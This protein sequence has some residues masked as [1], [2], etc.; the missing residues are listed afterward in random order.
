[1][2]DKDKRAIYDQQC[3]VIRKKNEKQ[4]QSKFAEHERRKHRKS[5]RKSRPKITRLPSHNGQKP[6][7][8]PK[9][10]DTRNNASKESV[11]LSG[12]D[13]DETHSSYS[14]AQLMTHLEHRIDM[15]E[16]EIDEL[17]RLD[18]EDENDVDFATRWGWGESDG[19]WSILNLEH[20]CRLREYSRQEKFKEVEL[21][22]L[23]IRRV[24]NEAALGSG[25]F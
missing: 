5:R 14:H 22:L 2:K 24:E 15:I 19:G 1:L 18:M 20:Q 8:R 10:V 6:Q 12:S 21:I 23:E 17:D 13:P 7:G 3:E 16:E 4:Q 25:L 9:H 11:F